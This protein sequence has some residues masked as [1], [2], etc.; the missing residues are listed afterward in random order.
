MAALLCPMWKRR[1]QTQ[2]TCLAIACSPFLKTRARCDQRHIVV[3]Q[4]IEP[5]QL[6]TL[7]DKCPAL[8]TESIRYAYWQSRR[9]GFAIFCCQIDTASDQKRRPASR[10]Y[11][12]RCAGGC[13][14]NACY[15]KRSSPNVDC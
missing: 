12:R 11:D 9:I 6:T 8:I 14:R 13:S 1:P 5:S 3:D 15:R 4:L 7:V 2:L 10:Q